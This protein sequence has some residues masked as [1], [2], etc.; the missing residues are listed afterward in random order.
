MSQR[1]HLARLPRFQL[2]GILGS[3]VI[4]LG[5]KTKIF[6]FFSSFLGSK[7]L[8]VVHTT[9][10]TSEGM[11][12][13]RFSAGK[14]RPK[15]FQYNHLTLT[16]D[17]F[18]VTRNTFPAF[19]QILYQQFSTFH[20]TLVVNYRSQASFARNWILFTAFLFLRA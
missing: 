8:R 9:R 19:C 18:H 17:I 6:H 7:K 14:M 1:I 15:T 5:K 20:S 16:Y 12:K 4:L 11:W 3:K 2:P 13:A 10:L